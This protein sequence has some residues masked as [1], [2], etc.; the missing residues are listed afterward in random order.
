MKKTE[1]F[2]IPGSKEIEEKV[3]V[4]FGEEV[5]I[6]VKENIFFR[7]FGLDMIIPV[8][9][10]SNGNSFPFFIRAFI[11]P[12]NPKWLFAGIFHDYLY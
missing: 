12:Y 5:T 2:L 7:A 10:I 6:E 8:G 3:K 1:Y 4:H 9:F 11:D